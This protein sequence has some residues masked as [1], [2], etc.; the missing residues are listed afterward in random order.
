MV[1]INRQCL[2]D[3]CPRVIHSAV[4]ICKLNVLRR[5]DSIEKRPQGNKEAYS[6][7]VKVHYHFGVQMLVRLG[8]ELNTS[9]FLLAD[10]SAP[11]C[12]SREKL[13]P[14]YLQG[15]H[16]LVGQGPQ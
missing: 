2:Q 15:R 13:T 16:R 3:G 12:F 1:I 9:E 7:C 5:E 6:D 10:T 8:A 4:R 14:V 11:V